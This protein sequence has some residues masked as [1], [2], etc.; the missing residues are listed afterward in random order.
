LERTIVD[1]WKDVLGL[2]TIGVDDDFFDLGGHSFA[3]L[4]TVAAL[5]S[6]AGLS[7]SLGGLLESRTVAR[8]AQLLTGQRASEA[9]VPLHAGSGPAVFMVH[10]AGGSVAAYRELARMLGRPCFG[11]AAS[12]PLPDTLQGLAQRYVAAIRAAAPGP[13]TLLGWSSGGVIALEMAAQLEAMGETVTR[14]I[15]LDAPAPTDPPPGPVDQPTMRDWFKEDTAGAESLAA[16][17]HHVYPVFA[18]VVNACRSYAPA[19]VSADV[20]LIRARDGLVSEYAAH[21]QTASAD[22]GWSGRTRGAVRAR[23]VAGTHHSLFSPPYID[24]VAAALR[25]LVPLEALE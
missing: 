17:L 19:T 10:P 8:L 3:A 20:V 25:E 14:L 13:Y 6:T 16:E 15:V 23:V 7:L 4:R 12:E 5:R 2:D 18:Q 11:L 24:E 9:L 1:V 22:W 21:P